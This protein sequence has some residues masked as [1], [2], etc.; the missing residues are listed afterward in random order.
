MYQTIN[1]RT[2]TIIFGMN[3]FEQVGIEAKKLG[4]SRVLLVTGP[5]V[6][7]TGLADRALSLLKAESIE[8]ELNIQ[9]RNTP[10]PSA[11]IPEEVALVAR[12]MKA[13]VIIGM[14]GGSVLDV[15]KMASALLTNPLRVRDYFG[16]EK[17]P[18]RGK[19]TIMIPT[20][21]GTGAEVTKH[22]I[23]LDEETSVK[24]AVASMALLP[25]TAIVDPLLT[26]S[27]PPVVTANAGIDAFIHAAEPFVSKGANPLTDSIAL[28]SMSLIAESL[29]PAFADGENLDARYNMAL[30]SLMSALVLNNSGTS[31][32]HALAY[33]IGGE[34]HVPHGPSLTCLMLACFDYIMVAAPERFAL[35]AE[36]MGE[37][38]TGLTTREASGLSLVA[39]RNFLKK[40]N[41]PVSLTDLDITDR[42]RVDQWAIAGHAEQRLLSNAIRKLSV[43][44]VKIIYQNSF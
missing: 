18:N 28:R 43:E 21:A 9:G 44:D 12:E 26:V 1:F 2:P 22:A 20:T 30:G 17:V 23:F 4:A 37:N 8:V 13:D 3:T 6:Q 5:N 10:E 16:K 24:K 33:P 39:I 40:L 11:Y 41:L 34:Y 32:V 19:P 14:G 25:N 42:S 29:G 38:I 36:A 35:M 31:L 15:A 7:K 27:C